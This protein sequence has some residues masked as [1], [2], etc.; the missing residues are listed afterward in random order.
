MFFYVDF[1]FSLQHDIDAFIQ[2]DGKSEHQSGV[3]VMLPATSL[4]KT[5]AQ[6]TFRP[7]DLETIRKCLL[8]RERSIGATSFDLEMKGKG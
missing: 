1:R 3:V 7:E 6:S 8:F 4:L 5:P 2:R